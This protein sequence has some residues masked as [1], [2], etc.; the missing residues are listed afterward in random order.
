MGGHRHTYSRPSSSHAPWSE[1]VEWCKATWRGGI[2]IGD[3][4]ARQRPSSCTCL[5]CQLSTI[6]PLQHLTSRQSSRTNSA[7]HQACQRAHAQELHCL[8]RSLCRRAWRSAAQAGLLPDLTDLSWSSG[9]RS[10]LPG[11]PLP[12]RPLHSTWRP[13]PSEGAKQ[14]QEQVLFLLKQCQM[15]LNLLLAAPR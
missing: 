8:M 13:L 4:V 3:R 10:N 15:L 6:I 12:R 11:Q 2:V 7:Q 1:V 9:L 14:W 5:N